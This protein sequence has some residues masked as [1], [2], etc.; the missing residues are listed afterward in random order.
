M[1]LLL[2]RPETEMMRSGLG[3]LL[4]LCILQTGFGQTSHLQHIQEDELGQDLD[5]LS[6]PDELMMLE[7]EKRAPMRFGKRMISFNKKAPMRFG[8]RAPMRFGKRDY[9]EP[10]MRDAMYEDTIF[11]KRAPMRFGKRSDLLDY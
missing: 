8:K 6:T 3:G 10:D 5:N 4:L 9:E 2:R 1:G 11:D 7:L